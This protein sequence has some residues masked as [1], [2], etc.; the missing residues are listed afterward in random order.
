LLS[1]ETVLLD[2]IADLVLLFAGDAASIGFSNVAF[3]VWHFSD[4]LG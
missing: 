4:P 2:E 1:A 3:I